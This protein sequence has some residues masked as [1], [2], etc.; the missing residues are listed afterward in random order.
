[1]VTIWV[2]YH[3]DV[4]KRYTAGITA[5]L[6]CVTHVVFAHAAE[7][8]FWAQ[9]AETVRRIRGGS[10]VSASPL[11]ADIPLTKQSILSAQGGEEK[12]DWLSLLGKYGTL[13]DF[14]ARGKGPVLFIQDVHGHRQAQENIGALIL[15][16]LER[17]PKASV[18]L[19]GASGMIPVE[20]FRGKDPSANRGAAG[21][22]FNVGIISGAEYGILGASKTPMVFGGEDSSLY[23]K[24]RDAIDRAALQKPGWD[25]RLGDLSQDLN[26]LKGRIYSQKLKELDQSSI[27]WSGGEGLLERA[28]YLA[29]AHRLPPPRA[30][31]SLA[32]FLR[33]ERLEKTISFDQADRERN[34]FIKAL[35][36]RLSVRQNESLLRAAMAFR[37]GR[38]T[39]GRFYSELQSLAKTHGVNLTRFPAFKSYVTY[40]LWADLLSPDSLLTE[41]EVREESLW[42]VLA[43]SPAQRELRAL[44]RD[45]RL[46]EGLVHLSLTPREWA[47]YKGRRTEIRQIYQRT[48]KVCSSLADVSIGSSETLMDLLAPF[49]SFYET[50]EAR[51]NAL[52]RHVISALAECP[53][54]TPVVLVAGGFHAEG[55]APLFSEAGVGVLTVTPRL[56]NSSEFSGAFALFARDKTPLE[57]LFDSPQI[58]LSETSTL[59]PL[60]PDGEARHQ[61][62]AKLS[63]PVAELLEIRDSSAEAIV[64]TA[65]DDLLI[66]AEK[67]REPSPV[68]PGTTQIYDRIPA[69]IEQTETAPKISIY[70]LGSSSWNKIWK[71][72]RRPTGRLLSPFLILA[73][74]VP[75]AWSPGVHAY[76]LTERNGAV[77]VVVQ[78]GEHLWGAAAHVLKAN[79]NPA[80][81]NGAIEKTVKE[82]ARLN[83]I[84]DPNLVHPGIAYRVPGPT[85]L[86]VTA[87]L[88]TISTPP[89]AGIQVSGTKLSE[90]IETDK[91]KGTIPPSSG[92]VSNPDKTSPE[93][94]QETRPYTSWMYSL[95]AGALLSI[96]LPLS[97]I[98]LSKKKESL[99]G[100]HRLKA[101]LEVVRSKTLDTP[102]FRQWVPVAV[103]ALFV[104]FLAFPWAS[105]SF[106][107]VEGVQSLISFVVG[108][109]P[110]ELA[111][112]G[113]VVGAVYYVWYRP[114]K[115]DLAQ[116]RKNDVRLREWETVLGE[117]MGKF[118]VDE[119]KLSR[120]ANN[121]HALVLNNRVTAAALADRGVMEKRI[122]LYRALSEL[123]QKTVFLLDR[124]LA[125]NTW[126]PEEAGRIADLREK[127]FLFQL[128]GL[129]VSN[130]LV[131]ASVTHWALSN[132]DRENS[133]FEQ[134]K[135]GFLLRLVRGVPSMIAGSAQECTTRMLV[136]Q[137]VPPGTLWDQAEHLSVVNL[138]NI[139]IPGLYSEKDKSELKNVFDE[140]KEKTKTRELSDMAAKDLHRKGWG[141]LTSILIWTVA[142][143]QVMSFFP[144]LLGFLT[145]LGVTM[146]LF[147]FQAMGVRRDGFYREAIALWR[148][149][150]RRPHANGRL[151]G[152][153]ETAGEDP[154]HLNRDF[155]RYHFGAAENALR[156]ELE[157]ST[158]TADIVILV[159]HNEAEKEYFE[160]RAKDPRL[161]RSDVPVVVLTGNRVGSF[162]AY[163]QAWT[164]LYS[165]DFNRLRNHHPHLRGRSP[166][167]LG[168]ITLVSKSGNVQGV[169]TPLTD[170][171]QFNERIGRESLGDRDVFDL[172]LMNAYRGTQAG[173]RQD[174]GGMVLRWA[175]R[176]YVGPVR[177]PKGPGVMLDTQWANQADMT[178]YSFGAVI[179]SL[180]K[181]IELIRRS[182]KQKTLDYL[183]K[184]HGNRVYDFSNDRLKQVQ[185]FSGEGVYAFDQDGAQAQVEFLREV[186]GQADTLSQVPNDGAPSL[187]LMTFFLVPL[188]LAQKGTK[189]MAT[190]IGAYFARLGFYNGSLPREIQMFNLNS[191]NALANAFAG[192][193]KV[194]LS[195]NAAFVD[196]S[197]YASSQ[198]SE[199]LE[200][201]SMFGSEPVAPEPDR[202]VS[203]WEGF[204]QTMAVFVLSLGA[205]ASPLSSTTSHSTMDRPAVVSVSGTASLQ[206]IQ[207][208]FQDRPA[209]SVWNQKL[210]QLLVW[211][212]AD[213]PLEKNV[214]A[215]F[216]PAWVRQMLQPGTPREWRGGQN[217]PAVVDDHSGS[218]EFFGLTNEKNAAL[219]VG[220]VLVSGLAQTA[221][222]SQLEFAWNAHREGR[223][224]REELHQAAYLQ[225][226]AGRPWAEKE[227]ALGFQK[228]LEDLMGVDGSEASLNAWKKGSRVLA[229]LRT[230]MRQTPVRPPKTTVT[231]I[232]VSELVEPG[233]KNE[234]HVRALVAQLEAR[235][236]RFD[237]QQGDILIINGLPGF[238]VSQAKDLLRYRLPPSPERD[239]YFKSSRV[240]LIEEP[241]FAPSQVWD[242]LSEAEKSGRS[243]DLYTVNPEAIWVDP[244]AKG[245][246]RVLLLEWVSGTLQSIDLLELARQAIKAA[247]V[248]NSNA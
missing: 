116:V 80:P 200:E 122:D 181:P 55:L 165:E 183:A 118:S 231:A 167:D 215:S 92:A 201:P 136:D 133:W 50:A 143:S 88:E 194:P 237:P 52:A 219:S 247:F 208:A 66:L 217:F 158:P 79:G 188:S 146:A 214:T 184:E 243:L 103:I 153:G 14:Q 85:S 242:G 189:N 73:A 115:T 191:A 13:R 26:S 197:I 123:S 61:A 185:A 96:G 17:F 121:V 95:F 65:K 125:G 204:R 132:Y 21:F 154:F 119:E 161:F 159:A 48:E 54:G 99:K 19:E 244:Q 174:Q 97:L 166:A 148:D 222:A 162:Y 228:S 12:G 126:S 182:K 64:K 42:T 100:F 60:T 15:S 171:A 212:T 81:S 198:V 128:Y 20:R 41:L 23:R 175:D 233:Y 199:E 178:R 130:A 134:R 245:D 210:A 246:H 49:E 34:E 29:Q 62:L 53:S 56:G 190:A 105:L 77:H 28:V 221:L 110:V 63:G 203:W 22:F 72:V 138:G 107:T 170:L 238:D 173:R 101:A 142:I 40:I 16:V 27:Q 2:R 179:A 120:L 106:L 129:K 141:T 32:Q 147:R 151:N 223:V 186:L 59:A 226:L 82:M 177:C 209:D 86:E 211:A 216:D 8:N 35:S 156:S 206:S 3:C 230:R 229:K 149:M 150:N 127:F 108:Q 113:G 46:L 235:I 45:L 220:E 47:R 83:K 38:G 10:E 152:K 68:L 131:P 102:L 224:P 112:L 39:S 33:I 145:G 168:V 111:L 91:H 176:A 232:R 213:I 7:T 6:Y 164:F 155:A 9:R 234:S 44:D 11:F 196:E 70:R 117:M 140:L 157:S 139:L 76:T 236:R 30:G 84:G 94:Q 205:L 227:E 207:K 144:A 195:L 124:R 180:G 5:L 36:P 51:N 248:I 172:A 4:M 225:G 24:N 163:A 90:D 93:S 239:S 114:N 241:T 31:S 89:L 169:G 192:D 25:H 75:L 18:V 87:D 58:S 67:S 57:R 240:V 135:V 160:E 71:A 74:L 137:K 104:T 98:A 218:T 37:E 109:W 69:S 193:V 78:K 43:E 1:M 202:R 187:N